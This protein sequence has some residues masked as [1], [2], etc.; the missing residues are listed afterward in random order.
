MGFRHIP[1]DLSKSKF[2][3]GYLVS[4]CVVGEAAAVAL[5]CGCDDDCDDD[6]DDDRAEVIRKS[7]PA[8]RTRRS[9]SENGD[10]AVERMAK[11]SGER[12]LLC[13]V[14]GLW[15]R[16]RRRKG[17]GFLCLHVTCSKRRPTAHNFV[18]N[19]TNLYS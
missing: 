11:P 9:S 12:S 4:G 17:R 6:D 10:I 8:A 16:R 15:G 3:N 13:A 14:C 5:G 7:P 18:L 19:P 1:V 2:R